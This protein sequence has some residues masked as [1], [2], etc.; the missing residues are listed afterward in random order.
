M[1]EISRAPEDFVAQLIGDTHSYPDGVVFF[2]GTMFA[3]IEDRDEPGQGF[4]H[5]VGDIVTV[6]S[7]L[8]GTLVNRVGYCDQIP[9]WEYGLRDLMRSLAARGLL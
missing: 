8:L 2:T 3:P 1:A 9:R 6:S 4:T 7:P 5:K